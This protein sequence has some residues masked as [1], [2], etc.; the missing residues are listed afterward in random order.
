[1]SHPLI[2][3]AADRE[4]RQSAAFREAAARLTGETLRT[5][6]D[7]EKANAPRLADAGKPYFVKRSGK[8]A[9]ERKKT[10]DLEHLGAGILRWCAD[11]E[12]SLALPD[13]AGTLTLLDYH[14]RAKPGRADE[15]ETKGINRFDALGVLDDGRLAV[16]EMR[17]LESSATRCGVGDTPLRVLLEGLLYTAIASANRE[18]IASEAQER[19]G[20]EISAE[21]PALVVLASARYWELCRKRSTQKG[22]H[23]IKEL[24]R[25]AAEIEEGTGV[26]VR[27]LSL[28]LQGDPGWTYD[29]QGSLLDGA[30]LLMDAWEPGADRIKPKPRPRPKTVAPRDEVVEADLSKP[31]RSYAFTEL[32]SAGERIEHPVLGTGVVQ[33]IAGPGKIRVRFDEKQSVLVHGRPG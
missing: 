20:R 32:Y 21:E 31:P 26:S 23:W 12:K 2:E 24:V 13:D 25:L 29:E 28:R 6:Y 27:F 5:A 8:P 16:V 14:V 10:R 4:V 22:A 18:Q 7:A 33:G 19:F 17:Y 1:M 11:K 15:P 3:L 9:T 30:P